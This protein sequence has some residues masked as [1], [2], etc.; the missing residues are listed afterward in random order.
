MHFLG[1]KK[2]SEPPQSSPSPSAEQDYWHGVA[3]QRHR[4]RKTTTTRPWKCQF[5]E[6]QLDKGLLQG[7]LRM[8][9]LDAVVADFG[10]GS[11]QYSKWLNDTGPWCCGFG[12]AALVGVGRRHCLGAREVLGSSSW[13]RRQTNV[14]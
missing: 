7:M 3:P 14:G 9:P 6:Y 10:A 2:V 5:E 12:A 1:P 8:L 4:K 11:G 13:E